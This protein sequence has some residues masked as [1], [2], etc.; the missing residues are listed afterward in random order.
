MAGNRWNVR[1]LKERVKSAL[2]LVLFLLVLQG[3]GEDPQGLFDTAQF[4]E[5]QG[6]RAHA[7]ELY[8]RIIRDHPDSSVAQQARERLEAWKTEKQ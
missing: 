4:E 7:Q 8:Q 3:C 2:G 5:K 6:N 1:L